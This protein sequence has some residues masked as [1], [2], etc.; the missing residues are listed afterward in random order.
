MNYIVSM[1]ELKSLL[2]LFGA[3]ELFGLQSEDRELSREDVV[4]C[5]ADLAKREILKP[6]NDRF[7]CNPEVKTMVRRIAAPKRTMLL[8]QCNKGLP[9]I[10]GYGS[11]GTAYTFV[12]K[13]PLW[14]DEY[15]L[16]QKTAEELAAA[17]T[18]EGYLPEEV[19][20]QAESENEIRVPEYLHGDQI[21][22][23][24]EGREHGLQF[25]ADFFDS[26]THQLLS[27]G[28]VCLQ[29]EQMTFAV[30]QGGKDSAER[31][32]IEAFTSWL[33]QMME[34]GENDIS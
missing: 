30:S 33:R 11:D 10:C 8:M 24:L 4:E 17:L 32:R 1:R 31:Y 18:E 25:W 27:R 21:A 34:V 19:P 6:E 12:E 2:I 29:K 9:Q 3:K 22:L 16:T 20:E 28:A 23:I 14:E 5:I 15:R 13:M 26:E 7:V